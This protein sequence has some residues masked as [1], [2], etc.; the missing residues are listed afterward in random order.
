V[1]A[2]EDTC[3]GAGALGADDDAEVGCHDAGRPSDDGAALGVGCHADGAGAAGADAAAPQ[4]DGLAG[5]G[6]LGCDG[7]CG[8]AACGDGREAPGCAD[9]GHCGSPVGR[10]IAGEPA[11]PAPVD[12]LRGGRGCAGAGAFCGAADGEPPQADGGEPAGG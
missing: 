11:A 3:H 12:V 2:G 5:C 7:A 9:P 10:E 8:G 6:E 4:A 1:D